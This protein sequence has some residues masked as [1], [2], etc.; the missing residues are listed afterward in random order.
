M[1]GQFGLFL[2]VYAFGLK[3]LED[4]NPPAFS[5][6]ASGSHAVCGAFD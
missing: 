3:G 5:I 2:Y 1:C 6:F 4:G